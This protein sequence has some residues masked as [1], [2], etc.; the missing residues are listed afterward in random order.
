MC[1]LVGVLGN[2]TPKIEKVFKDMLVFDSVRG[3]DST[4]VLF[5]H[6]AVSGYSVV[7]EAVAPHEFMDGGEFRHRMSFLNKVLMGHNRWATT[8]YVNDT[9]AHPFDFDNIVGMHNGT[10]VDQTLLDDHKHFEVDSENIFW[11][12][13]M[14]GVADTVSKLHGAYA[15]NWYNKEERT[16][17]FIRNDQRPLY[18]ILTEDKKTLFW[19][20][21]P[22]MIQ[23]AMGRHN[24]KGGEPQALTVGDHVSFDIPD[25][26]SA[27]QTVPKAVVKPLKM[28]VPPPKPAYEEYW[29]L[30]AYNK[31]YQ[32][33]KQLA[34]PLSTR[35]T[36]LIGCHTNFEVV[37]TGVESGSEYIN[38]RHTTWSDINIRV[39]CKNKAVWEQMLNSCNTFSGRV[40][41]YNKVTT[42]YLTIDLRT[43]KENKN[44]GNDAYIED[45]M[46]DDVD[47]ADIVAIGWRGVTLT[48]D[49]YYY[50][51]GG[52]C[53][54]CTGIT[55]FEDSHEVSWVSEHEHIC[56]GCKDL[57][58]VQN[59]INAA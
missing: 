37:G 46:F 26:F 14:H 59:A 18:F 24:V 2:I 29:G 53:A 43:I 48:E 41:A 52:G 11:H 6:S 9:N 55:Y 31:D 33:K 54:W 44:V 38:C 34:D 16:V 21:E 12:M 28:F 1:G 19:A 30:Q 42:P 17:N 49:E 47:D 13:E 35:Y 45:I 32:A 15:L 4:G 39:F 10:L 27:A 57:P 23:L 22:M 36:G 3:P 50:A 58:D 5:V 56:D 51:A 25:T 40:K 7:K 8:G 20:S